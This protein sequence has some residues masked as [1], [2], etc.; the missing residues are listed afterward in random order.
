MPSGHL[1][2]PKCKNWGMSNYYFYESRNYNKYIFYNRKEGSRECKCW[3]LLYHCGY[4]V[5]NPIDPCGLL[6]AICKSYKKDEAEAPV[7]IEYENGIEKRRY[8]DSCGYC[9]CILYLLVCYFILAFYVMI[10]FWYDLYYAFFKKPKIYKIIC[11]GNGSKIVP[12]EDVLDSDFNIEEYWC[13]N[14]PNLF[15]CT[16]SE[17]GYQGESFKEFMDINQISGEPVNI[18]SIQNDVTNTGI[19]ANN[20]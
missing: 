12:E 18:A 3:A 2:C 11:T 15:K 1:L 17:C 8:K 14:F 7:V 4:T 5:H 16:N 6:D 19:N 9:Y 20:E 13:N 10:F